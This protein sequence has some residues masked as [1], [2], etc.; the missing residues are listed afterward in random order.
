MEHLLRSSSCSEVHWGTRPTPLKYGIYVAATITPDDRFDD[1]PIRV[2]NFQRIPRKIRAGT[3]IGDL[4]AVTLMS[5]PA[6]DLTDGSFELQQSSRTSFG[7]VLNE[8][9]RAS[10]SSRSSSTSQSA[11][12]D[13]N[14]NFR[15]VSDERSQRL[16]GVLSRDAASR[17]RSTSTVDVSED[18]TPKYIEQLVDDVDPATPKSSVL[19]LQGPVSY[20]H[21]TLPTIYSV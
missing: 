6:A 21:L 10:K 3:T 2:M 11:E 7:D 5:S 20:T 19:S 18:S 15:R 17:I 12:R 1:I 4:E 8:N 13:V 9:G 16:R 14:S